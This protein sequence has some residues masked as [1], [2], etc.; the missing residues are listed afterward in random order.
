MSKVAWESAASSSFLSILSP[1][2]KLFRFFGL[3]FHEASGG[4]PIVIK[5]V[6]YFWLVISLGTCVYYLAVHFP[7]LFFSSYR[8]NNSTG[9][10]H[11]AIEFLNYW[12]YNLAIVIGSLWMARKSS[13]GPLWSAVEDLLAQVPLSKE[14]IAKCR[15]TTVQCTIGVIVV[16]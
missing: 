15:K 6:H 11:Y 14:D 3:N 10:L 7:I 9:F 5:V 13:A 8:L 1:I 16:V 2:F 4:H 12:I